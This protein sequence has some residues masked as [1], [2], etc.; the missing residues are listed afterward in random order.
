MKNQIKKQENDYDEY[1]TLFI[2]MSNI[3]NIIE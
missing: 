1:F 2:R 3:D